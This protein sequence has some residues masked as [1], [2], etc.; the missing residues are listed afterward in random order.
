MI[1]VYEFAGTDYDR[2]L[3][4]IVL[5]ADMAVYDYEVRNI[6]FGAAPWDEMLPRH[7]KSAFLQRA[8]LLFDQLG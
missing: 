8:D 3:R 1:Q 4:D 6:R 5:D 7:A 2:D